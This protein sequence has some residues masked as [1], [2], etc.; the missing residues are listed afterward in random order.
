MV[1]MTLL[2]LESVTR[3]FPAGLEEFSV[4]DDVSFQVEEGDFIGLQG[5]RRSGKS[6]LLRIAAGWERPNEGR[7]L[8]DGQDLWQL[9]DGARARLRRSG[10]IALASGTWRPPSN[11]PALRHLQ[12]T[13]ACNRVSMRE[14]VEPTLRV[15]ERVGLSRSAYTPSDRLS[16]GELIRLGLAVRLIH[17]PRLLLIDEPA[18]LLRPSEA[19]ELYELLGSLGRERDLA[20]LIASEELA[21]IRIASRRFSLDDGRLRS[22]ERPSGQVLEFP[23]PR[24]ARG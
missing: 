8:L 15:L 11:K 22:M 7:V 24:A 4:L 21:P 18:V 23:D 20:L 1:S 12:E 19:A 16:P 6:I 10:G 5:E 13:L 3:R 14:A 9:S 17:G 2:S